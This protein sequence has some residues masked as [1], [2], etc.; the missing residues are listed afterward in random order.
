MIY[1]DSKTILEVCVY[2]QPVIQ[3]FNVPATTPASFAV[4]NTLAE[5]DVLIAG[6]HTVQKA[7]V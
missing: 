3:R 4:Y 1:Q 6:I 7:L 5:I 2:A